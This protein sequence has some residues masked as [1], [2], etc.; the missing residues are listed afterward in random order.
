MHEAREN[1]KR[2]QCISCFFQSSTNSNHAIGIAI[3][4]VVRRFM[5]IPTENYLENSNIRAIE[6]MCY[7]ILTTCKCSLCLNVHHF[8]FVRRVI[9]S[10]IFLISNLYLYI[11]EYTQAKHHICLYVRGVFQFD[12]LRYSNVELSNVIESK[13]TYLYIHIMIYFW[14]SQMLVRKKTLSGIILKISAKWIQ[15]MTIVEANQQRTNLL[16]IIII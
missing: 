12:S 2:V 7:I 14:H 10:Y 4:K 6:I 9:F 3:H 16:M 8:P 15:G 11:Y 1:Q 5:R 13:Y